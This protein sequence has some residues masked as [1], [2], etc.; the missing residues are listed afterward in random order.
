MRILSF[1]FSDSF[2][3]SARFA[4]SFF[5]SSSALASAS[6]LLIFGFGAAGGRRG[7]SMS[8]SSSC[9]ASQFTACW[10]LA[11]SVL[12]SAFSARSSE[13]PISMTSLRSSWL[14]FSLISGGFGSP[15]LRS[16]GAASSIGTSPSASAIATSAAP[17]A[18]ESRNSS[19]SLSRPSSSACAANHASAASRVPLSLVKSKAFADRTLVCPF[20][21]FNASNFFWSTESKNLSLLLVASSFRFC[22]SRRYSIVFSSN[23]LESG[24]RCCILCTSASV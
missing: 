8:A 23:V 10:R 12:K 22:K 16:S 7:K 3:S 6:S 1:S 18:T 17:E 14:M 2:S 19:V 20:T 4:R 21:V 13:K 11:L 24:S 5:C 9:S 15:T